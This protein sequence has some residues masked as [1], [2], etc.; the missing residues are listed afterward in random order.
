MVEPTPTSATPRIKRAAN[1]MS[2]LV[3]NI[4]IKLPIAAITKL[5]KITGL[6]PIRS[7]IGPKTERLS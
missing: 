3:A 5:H 2:K 1:N 4:A 7:E 6:R